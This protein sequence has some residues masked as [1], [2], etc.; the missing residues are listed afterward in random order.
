MKGL[1]K[2]CGL[3]DRS[4]RFGMVHAKDAKPRPGRGKDGKKISKF[5]FRNSKVGNHILQRRR[6]DS[7]KLP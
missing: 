2:R 7:F 4:V 5:G 3:S 1:R 6:E